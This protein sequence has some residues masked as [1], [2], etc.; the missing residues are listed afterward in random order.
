MTTDDVLAALLT[1]DLVEV[2]DNDERGRRYLINGT[3]LNGVTELEIICRIEGNLITI[4]V[5]EAY[6]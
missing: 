4:T 3:A 1:G 2:L 5:Y 6:F